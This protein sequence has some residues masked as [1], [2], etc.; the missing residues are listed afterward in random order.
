MAYASLVGYDGL[1][2]LFIDVVTTQ[3]DLDSIDNEECAV[4]DRHAD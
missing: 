2:G 1:R 4:V 3:E